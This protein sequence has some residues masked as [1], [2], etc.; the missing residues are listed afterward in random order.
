MTSF[1]ISGLK[2]FSRGS[3]RKHCFSLREMRDDLDKQCAFEERLKKKKMRVTFKKTQ[4]KRHGPVKPFYNVKPQ[5]HILLSSILSRSHTFHAS[6]LVACCLLQTNPTAG[7]VIFTQ[8]RARLPGPTQRE[9]K[10]QPISGCFVHFY[11]V[12]KW[13]EVTFGI[14]AMTQNQL[15][16]IPKQ[17]A[18]HTHMGQ[19]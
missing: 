8:Q 19:K 1:N 18:T 17:K 4:K 12:V 13:N 9:T 7:R 15:S 2:G 14:G 11:I 6:S 16:F 3:F 5:H 10:T